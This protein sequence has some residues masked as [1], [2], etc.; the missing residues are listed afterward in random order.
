MVEKL[1]PHKISLSDQQ[2]PG[3]SSREKTCDL[4]GEEWKCF[5][6][7][8]VHTGEKGRRSMQGRK[9]L[10]GVPCFYEFIEYRNIF[11]LG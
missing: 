5:C 8:G 11:E 9:D 4:R 6:S 7:E 3:E 1:K 10:L 2:V